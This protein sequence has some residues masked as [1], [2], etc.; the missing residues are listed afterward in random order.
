L[1]GV[2]GRDAWSASGEFTVSRRRQEMKL[3]LYNAAIDKRYEMNSALLWER[4][5]F[6]R[7]MPS[8]QS[9][10]GVPDEL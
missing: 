2:L 5:I 4:S 1:P 8:D 6:R 9:N 3:I 10:S 7:L